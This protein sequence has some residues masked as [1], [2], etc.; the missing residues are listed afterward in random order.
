[1]GFIIL[2]FS[3]FIP[4]PCR[5]GYHRRPPGWTPELLVEWENVPPKGTEAVC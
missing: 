1:M 3:Q 5:G 4:A 2:C